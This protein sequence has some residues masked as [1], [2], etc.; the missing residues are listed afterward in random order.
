M[1]KS[2]I[3]NG[4]IGKRLISK[5]KGLKYIIQ[6]SPESED[7]GAKIGSTIVSETSIPIHY[8]D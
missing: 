8:R 3:I 1:G 5:K 2:T 6:L 4:L 7:K